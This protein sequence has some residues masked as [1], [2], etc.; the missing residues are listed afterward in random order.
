MH[1]L[2]LCARLNCVMCL[3]VY[4]VLRPPPAALHRASSAKAKTQRE[5][6]WNKE[7]RG[8]TPPPDIVIS[9]F[10][11]YIEETREQCSAHGAAQSALS[12]KRKSRRRKKNQRAEEQGGTGWEI[13][14]AGEIRRLIHRGFTLHSSFTTFTQVWCKTC[15]NMTWAQGRIF[16]SLRFGTSAPD[17]HQDKTDDRRNERNY[18]QRLLRTL[19]YNF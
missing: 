9:S 14:T 19:K 4:L 5:T 13:L 17:R 8:L 11:H 12:A 6:R 3:S 7:Q 16:V 10:S 18:K 1:Y 2:S 15:F